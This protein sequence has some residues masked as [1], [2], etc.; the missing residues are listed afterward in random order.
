M[1]DITRVHCL[2]PV[3]YYSV[4]VHDDVPDAVPVLGLPRHYSISLTIGRKPT[5]LV[6]VPANTP[7][8]VIHQRSTRVCSMK[9]LSAYMKWKFNHFQRSLDATSVR[10]YGLFKRVYADI[11]WIKSVIN[12]EFDYHVGN[13]NC[14]KEENLPYMV[15]Y[16]K[17][18]FA[19]YGPKFCDI[20]RPDLNISES[21][22]AKNIFPL[23]NIIL[24]K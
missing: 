14:L 12:V 24:K 1:D 22:L 8:Y 7:V 4:Y 20:A 5:V 23:K 3:Y 17:T 15:E 18:Q 9:I 10:S 11:E 2:L 13:R 21:N 19:G 6:K 16:R